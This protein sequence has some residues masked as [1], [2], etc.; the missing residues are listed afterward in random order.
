MF[1]HVLMEMK[2]QYLEAHISRA[3]NI[4]VPYLWGGVHIDFGA[5]PVVISISVGVTLS[6]LRSILWTSG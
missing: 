3:L 6:C 5:D 4:Y 2:G 1:L